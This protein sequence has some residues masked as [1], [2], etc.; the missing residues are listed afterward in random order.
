V[1]TC[2]GVKAPHT[3]DSLMELMIALLGI[4]AAFAAT[5]VALQA[6][7]LVWKK[8]RVRRDAIRRSMA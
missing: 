7:T 5:L 4:A 3:Q 2:V 8:L 1:K 6:A